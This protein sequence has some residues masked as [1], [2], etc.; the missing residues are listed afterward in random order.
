MTAPAEL[1]GGGEVPTMTQKRKTP[2]AGGA[3]N[4]AVLLKQIN[5]ENTGN[6]AQTQRERILSA[7]RL[8]GSVTTLECSRFLSIVH[9]PR[10]VMELRREGIGILTAWKHEPDE[11]GRLHRVGRYVLEVRT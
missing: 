5:R 1:Y 2:L 9:P 6:A 3:G 11:A 8:L 4:R 10:R 7:L